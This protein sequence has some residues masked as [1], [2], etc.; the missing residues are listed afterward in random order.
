ML[1]SLRQNLTR[2]IVD[3]DESM[4]EALKKIESEASSEGSDGSD[5]NMERIVKR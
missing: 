2:R 4:D 1:L 5:K 3:A